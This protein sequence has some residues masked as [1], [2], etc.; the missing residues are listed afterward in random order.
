MDVTWYSHYFVPEIGAPSARVMDLS[1]EWLHTGNHC[2]VVTCYPNH[3]TGKLYPGYRLGWHMQ[4]SVEDV[5]VHRLWTYITPN[6]GVIRKTLGHISFMSSALLT[7]TKVTGPADVVIGTSPTLFAAIA[8][9]AAAARRHVPFV[10]DVRD[11]WPASFSE[12]GVLK[13]RAILRALELLELWLYRQA[14][15][16]VTVTDSFRANLLARGVPEGKV[17]AVPNGA[18]LD[19]WRRELAKPAELRRELGLDGKFVVLYIGAHGISQRL[20]TVI[21]AAGLLRDDPSVVFIFVG[22]GAEKASLLERART[23]NS[24]NIRFFDSVS[25]AR[26]RDYYAMADVCLVPLRDIPL[27]RTFIPSKMFEILSMGTPVL[28]SVA[29]ESADILRRSDGAMVVPPEDSG[30]LAYAIRELRSRDTNDMRRRGR[31]FVEASYSRRALAIRYMDFLE[32]TRE[33][34]RR[35]KS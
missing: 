2:R 8:A 25:K 17:V 4:E 15:G 33:R 19:Y 18:D 28:A 3:P 22:E 34:F 10:M 11:L 26:V 30:A 6:R 31:S 29:G 20:S 12:L 16:V 7:G 1:R 5:D 14:S 32:M 23:S 24:S 35:E 13:N 27:F 9:A 21:D